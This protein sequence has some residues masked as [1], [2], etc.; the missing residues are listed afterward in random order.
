MR[1]EDG[2]ESLRLA[3]IAFDLETSEV[4]RGLQGDQLRS[5]EKLAQ[6]ETRLSENALLRETRFKASGDPWVRTPLRAHKQAA[7][8]RRLY[9]EVILREEGGRSAIELALVS[10]E[11]HLRLAGIDV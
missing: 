2:R 7:I 5:F 1:S 11:R 9:L 8:R 6:E 3:V 4:A 10:F